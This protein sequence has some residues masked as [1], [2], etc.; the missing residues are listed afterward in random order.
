MPGET[1]VA[2]ATP[3][4]VGAI[5][6]VRIAGLQT[7]ELAARI[8][9]SPRALRAR[10]ATRVRVVDENG[11]RIDDALAVLFA[12]PHSYTGEDVLEIHLH[13][14]PAIVREVLRASIACGARLARAGEFTQRAFL[15]GKLDLHAAAAVGDLIAAEHRSAV[16]A[17]LANL[18]GTLTREV[19]A[20]RQRLL[21]LLEAL[22]GTLDF[23]DEV[24]EPSRVDIQRTLQDVIATLQLIQR[25][26][27]RG[28][29]LR[30]GTSVAIVGAP[31]AGKSSLL[32]ALLGEDRAIVSEIAGTTRDTI[33]ERLII[34]GVVV[35]LTDTAGIREHAD[36]VEGLGIERTR[37]ALDDARIALVVVDGSVATSEDTQRVLAQ[38]QMRRRLVFFNKAD[39]GSHGVHALGN[40]P[41][42]IGSVHDPR[43]VAQICD[44]IAQLGWDSG[45]LDLERAHI[46]AAHE[47]D[48]VREALLA[49]EEAYATA[50][51]GHPI[52][53]IAGDVQRASAALGKL[54]GDEATEELITGIFARFCVGK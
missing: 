11:V 23:P 8:V 41:T 48:A 12:A 6:V 3:P 17:A 45:E 27:E 10:M 42:V 28:R 2:L 7:R 51:S 13:G 49:L 15:N 33:E 50:I 40:T 9:S 19:R 26:G 32:N 43:T 36:R 14:S 16:R 1:I 5:S 34:R 38:T 24:P 47:F 25:Q 53:L 29:L 21:Q 46:T 39:R 44:A 37:R 52:D 22:A 35:R 54:S 18:G 20:A 4:G 30:E 31:N